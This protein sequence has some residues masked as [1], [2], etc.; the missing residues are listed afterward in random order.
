MT[1]RYISASA[2]KGTGLYDTQWKTEMKNKGC[3]GGWGVYAAF[4][5]LV[6]V[7]VVP[8]LSQRGALP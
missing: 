5:R 3:N 8:Y 4:S 6:L 7:D 2:G 1:S